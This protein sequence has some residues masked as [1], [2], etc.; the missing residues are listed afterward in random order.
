LCS[1]LPTDEDHFSSEADAAVSEMT[2]GAVLV[3]QVTNYDSVTGLPLIQLWNLMG[4]EVVSINRTLVERG[5]AR[6]L[7]YYRASL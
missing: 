7:D 3:A 6:W 5:F 1:L 4:D 2:R